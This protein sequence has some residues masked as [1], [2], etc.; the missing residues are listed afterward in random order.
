MAK[1]SKK[2]FNL[3]IGG[4]EVDEGGVDDFNLD[5]LKK[6]GKVSLV[7]RF[8]V[9]SP[10]PYKIFIISEEGGEPHFYLQYLQPGEEGHYIVSIRIKDLQITGF[11][12][13][14]KK[15]L[16]AGTFSQL[17]SF[18][19]SVKQPARTIKKGVTAWKFL[20]DCWDNENPDCSMESDPDFSAIE[21]KK[22]FTYA[23][24]LLAK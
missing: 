10:P 16:A 20:L 7:G 3:S 9:P 12:A 5:G 17:V 18:L 14:K 23:R 2:A 8:S 6:H 22:D 21:K 1:R 11:R 19:K 24:G 15:R 4:N 13:G